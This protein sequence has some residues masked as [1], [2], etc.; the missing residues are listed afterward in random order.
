[1]NYTIDKKNNLLISFTQSFRRYCLTFLQENISF[2]SLLLK[3]I[4]QLN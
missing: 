4:E 3:L 1:M 2:G